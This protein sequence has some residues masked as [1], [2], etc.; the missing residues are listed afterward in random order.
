MYSAKIKNDVISNEKKTSS[1]ELKKIQEEEGNQR[2]GGGGIMKNGTTSLYG[3]RQ[4]F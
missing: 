1:A 4:W 3:V 2:V